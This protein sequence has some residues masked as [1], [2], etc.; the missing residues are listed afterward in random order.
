MEKRCWCQKMI[1]RHYEETWFIS[2]DTLALMLAIPMLLAAGMLERSGNHTVLPEEQS[3][4]S[5]FSDTVLDSAEWRKSPVPKLRWREPSQ[6]SLGWRSPPTT[7]SSSSSSPRGIKLFPR[8][9]PGRT[10][11][12][13]PITREE[14]P[15]IKLFEFGS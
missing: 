4:R 5:N 12:F 2:T 1:H 8:Y 11:D 7:Q 15:L 9:R 10:T 3:Y 6:P 13:D 14:K